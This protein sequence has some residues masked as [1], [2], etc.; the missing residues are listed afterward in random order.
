M[1]ILYLFCFIL[2]LKILADKILAE[3]NGPNLVLD[4]PSAK[5]ATP[6]V[7]KQLRVLV[8]YLFIQP[9]IHPI[10]IKWLLYVTFPHYSLP[11]LLSSSKSIILFLK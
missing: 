11:H 7:Y 4:S 2:F 5:E 10:L 6:K 9:F 8:Y 3:S 1:E